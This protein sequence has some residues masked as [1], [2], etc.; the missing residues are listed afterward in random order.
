MSINPHIFGELLKCLIR[1]KTISYSSYL[2]KK[3]QGEEQNLENQ[4]KEL[5]TI[6]EKDPRRDIKNDILETE[7][8]LVIF[9][10][11]KLTVS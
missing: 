9:R 5:Q 1:G 8:K 4:L 11:K 10:E 2:K 7:E 6:Y 3:N